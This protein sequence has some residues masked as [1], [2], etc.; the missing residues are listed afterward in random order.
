MW[1]TFTSREKRLLLKALRQV[2]EVCDYAN[3]KDRQGFNKPD[4]ALGNSLARCSFLSD[5]QAF[6][7]KGL[8]R[9]YKRQIDRW[10]YEA[11]YSENEPEAV[12]GSESH[13]PEP[14]GQ[15]SEKQKGETVLAV[16]PVVESF[17]TSDGKE[18]L[19]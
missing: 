8:L 4:A 14:S 3:T 9:K 5:K 15:R 17:T 19:I 10:L 11:I 18:E 1:V 7:A 2:S 13:A 12:H 16:S 6:R